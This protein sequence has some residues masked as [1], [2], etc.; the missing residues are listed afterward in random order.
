M[1]L[2]PAPR[3]VRC[4][5]AAALAAPLLLL[6][7]AAWPLLAVAIAVLVADAVIDLLARPGPKGLE[8]TRIAPERLSVL[9]EATVALTVRNRAGVA[10]HVRL[11][12]TAPEVFHASEIEVGGPVP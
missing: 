9:A 8:V 5:A 11:R 12:D 10:L 4:A 1:S 6:F 7:P 3:L 2:V